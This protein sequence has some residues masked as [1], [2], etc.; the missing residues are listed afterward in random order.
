MIELITTDHEEQDC[1]FC[2]GRIFFNCRMVVD[3]ARYFHV[4]CYD[5]HNNR[6]NRLMA[7]D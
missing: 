4:G 2:G 5:A 6:L 1:K 7:G 3:S